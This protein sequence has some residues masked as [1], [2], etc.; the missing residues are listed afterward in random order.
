[1]TVQSLR[2]VPA[3]YRSPGVT[4]SLPPPLL[5]RGNV[6]A[7]SP[8][9]PAKKKCI[10][11]PRRLRDVLVPLDGS[12]HAEHALPW[13]LRIADETGAQIHLVHV[14]R[15]MKAPA[16]RRRARLYV[17]FDDLLRQPM[18]EYLSDL[19]R[20]LAR[21][22]SASVA[23]LWLDGREI[24]ESLAAMAQT[25]DLVIMATRRRSFA[26]R[27]LLG[28]ISHEVIGR[29]PAPTLLVP[30]Y[31]SPADLTGR[32]PLRRALVPLDGSKGS[33]QILKPLEKLSSDSSSEQILLRVTDNDRM[34]D[35]W[36]ARSYSQW[37]DFR[38][39]PLAQ[40]REVASK[41]KDSFPNARS[42]VVWSDTSAAR[43]IS[44]QARELGVDY[45]ALATRRRGAL[46]QFIK[47]GVMGHLVRSGTWPLLVVQ[48]SLTAL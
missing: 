44:Q 17:D 32:P 14:H 43:T 6:V 20:R 35:A 28:S 1:M 34:C 29:R 18:E 25:A 40:V 26:S 33:E 5:R 8:H 13:A 23:P 42:S 41:W 7:T 48:Q 27:L 38:N 22:S 39:G 2:R 11:V 31:D 30:G 21:T 4:S 10:P 15:P 16:H 3:D 12:R 9:R 46:R 37:S 24:D 19:A 45:I 36:D 47:P